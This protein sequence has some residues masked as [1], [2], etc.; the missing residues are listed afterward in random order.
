MLD[1]FLNQ[2]IFKIEKK[3]GNFIKKILIV[4]DLEDFLTVEVSIKKIPKKIEI[5]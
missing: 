5:K 2:N 1:N 4:T 3:I